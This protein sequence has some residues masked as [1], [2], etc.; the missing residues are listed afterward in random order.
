MG[1]N[2]QCKLAD[3]PLFYYFK[4]CMNHMVLQD[5]SHVTTFS[6]AIS[7]RHDHNENRVAS[8]KSNYH[9][10]TTDVSACKFNL[11]VDLYVIRYKSPLTYF[12]PNC[13]SK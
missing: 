12:N 8:C 1:L 9:I 2:T 3:S 6:H 4:L 11:V 7:L 13:I 5:D 10:L